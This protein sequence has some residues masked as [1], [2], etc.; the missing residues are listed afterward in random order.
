MKSAFF[1]CVWSILAEPLVLDL[2]RLQYSLESREV[3]GKTVILKYSLWKRQL[4]VMAGSGR[5]CSVG[6]KQCPDAGC[7]NY[8]C[9]VVWLKVR[10][11]CLQDENDIKYEQY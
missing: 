5:K 4:E 1:L 10:M 3:Y 9:L 8:R 11:F 6:W 2:D 7:L